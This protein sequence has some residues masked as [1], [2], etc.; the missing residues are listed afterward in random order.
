MLMVII[1]G[2]VTG[3]AVAVIIAI[4]HVLHKKVQAR[5]VTR[6]NE[7]AARKAEIQRLAQRRRTRI[8]VQWESGS[9]KEPASV[10]L[11]RQA[12]IRGREPAHPFMPGRSVTLFAVT[13]S[14][15][16]AMPGEPIT[17]TKEITRPQSADAVTH[18][19]HNGEAMR[20]NSQP[21]IRYEDL[22]SAFVLPI[23]KW[24]VIHRSGAD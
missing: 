24:R 21:A 20:S 10:A 4:I 16:R 18:W 11:L 2:V 19:P 17:A 3:L 5:R 14:H 8:S 1:E 12:K 15:L 6:A 9:L 13:G 23:T 7:L 22:F